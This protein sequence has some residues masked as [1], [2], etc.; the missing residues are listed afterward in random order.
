MADTTK[1]A[2]TEDESSEDEV[3]EAQIAVHWR[4]EERFHIALWIDQ[5]W[6]ICSC[7]HSSDAYPAKARG[8]APR[9]C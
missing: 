9:S 6:S 5:L 3:S 4:E 1:P 7:L 8:S 2:P